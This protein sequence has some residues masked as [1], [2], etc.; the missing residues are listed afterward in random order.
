MFT[1]LKILMLVINMASNTHVVKDENKKQVA[2]ILGE[3]Q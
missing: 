1:T 3:E 2:L